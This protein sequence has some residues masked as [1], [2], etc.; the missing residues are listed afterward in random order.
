MPCAENSRFA[1]RVTLPVNAFLIRHP[2]HGNILVDTGLSQKGIEL[3]PP[4]LIRFYRPEIK[5]GC[6]AQE[7]LAAMGLRPED[8]DLL[9]ITHNDADHTC[10]L[11]DFAG[12]AK[13][14]VMGEHEY[15]F[16]C[17]RVYKRRQVWETWMP[18]EKQID[19]RY[20][21]GTVQGP[22]GRGFDLFGDDSLL[23][24]ACP[25]HTDGHMAI[26]I[27]RAPSGRFAN[28]GSGIY[29]GDYAVIAAD[30]AFSQRNIDTLV[31]PGFGFSRERQIKSLQ[32]LS[33]LQ[34]DSKCRALLFSHS[35]AE[36]LII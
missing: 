33:G 17:R 34:K 16:S 20:Y 30:A 22:V 23:C 11:G 36:E 31:P 5:P 19:R 10:A 24:I 6:S 9:I 27:N 32:W 29:G 4:R 26:M 35:G 18:Y 1:S 14:I 3:F 25:G 7:Q 8:I 13:H 21:Y 15:F 28:A 2:V 12:R